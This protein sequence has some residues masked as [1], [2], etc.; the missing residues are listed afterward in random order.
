MAIGKIQL[1][2]IQQAQRLLEV[3]R[4][5]YLVEAKLIG[6][7]AIPALQEDLEALQNS[8]EI[9]YGCWIDG[10]L[11]GAISYKREGSLLDIYRLVVHPSYFRRG[12]GKALVSFVEEVEEGIER[13]IVSTGA[14]NLPAK[15]LYEVL[16]FSEIGERGHTGT[17]DYAF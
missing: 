17:V 10:E 13:I 14:R 8:D 3:Q 2:S 9:F 15:R 11:A 6:S 7:S 12:I 16:G 4:A 5:A 1:Q